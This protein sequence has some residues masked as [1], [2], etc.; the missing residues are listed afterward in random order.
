[1][2]GRRQTCTDRT[3]IRSFKAYVVQSTW[4]FTRLLLPKRATN[5][6]VFLQTSSHYV[7]P[8]RAQTHLDWQQCHHVIPTKCY[9]I[10][11]HGIVHGAPA[12]PRTRSDSNL[13]HGAEG[14]K[15]NSTVVSTSARH[16]PGHINP[17][18]P[19]N[20]PVTLKSKFLLS[21]HLHLDLPSDR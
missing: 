21:F 17:P 6:L 13:S 7:R 18:P 15:P 1:M 14:L 20:T 11:Y 9:T 4:K 16:I 12:H 8:N 10:S 3:L 19:T 5:N 2:R